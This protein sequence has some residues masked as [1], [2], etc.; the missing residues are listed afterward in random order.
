M[1]IQRVLAHT[2]ATIIEADELEDI[3]G[4]AGPIVIP[5]LK[6][7]GAPLIPDTIHDSH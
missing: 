5:T 6:I 7:T 3:S 4:G 2:L 1:E